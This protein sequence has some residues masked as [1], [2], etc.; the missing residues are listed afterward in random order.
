[1]FE[2]QKSPYRK[3]ESHQCCGWTHVTLIVLPSRTIWCSLK[4]LNHKCWPKSSKRN[5]RTASMNVLRCLSNLVDVNVFWSG[6][7]QCSLDSQ[8]HLWQGLSTIRPIE[9]DYLSSRSHVYGL[10][11][12]RSTS[13][14]A[15]V[16]E[17]CFWGER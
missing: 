5:C 17:G 9:L 12:K 3:V 4:G 1:M 14:L 15:E 11:G 10:T 8:S 2:N 16:P 6:N 13:N 7:P